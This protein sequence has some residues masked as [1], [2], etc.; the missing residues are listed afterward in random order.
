MALT[1][2]ALRIMDEMTDTLAEITAYCRTLA[3]SLNVPD[4]YLM[5]MSVILDNLLTADFTVGLSAY[6][7]ECSSFA[8]ASFKALCRTELF[9]A[10][11]L[12][13]SEIGRW[14][15]PLTAQYSVFLGFTSDWREKAEPLEQESYAV[16]KRVLRYA[17]T[18]ILDIVFEQYKNITVKLLNILRS[19][20]LVLS[21]PRIYL[22]EVMEQARQRDETGYR[23]EAYRALDRVDKDMP[24]C[25]AP[26]DLCDICDEHISGSEQ[27][28][29]DAYMQ[30]IN[31]C[32]A[33]FASDAP[34]YAAW[35]HAF[36]LPEQM[37]QYRQQLKYLAKETDTS[38]EGSIAN[39]I[40]GDDN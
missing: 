10:E 31:R 15:Q 35:T 25:Y 13:N 3:F 38:R 19:L 33:D 40:C 7:E 24:R 12:R 6:S 18:E 5:P 29:T 28:G 9:F 8:E 37:M 21:E 22:R 27:P 32:A 23:R 16:T 11:M 20:E 39:M 4:K 26:A 36:R 30:A 17:D 2:D 14:I 1:D 34:S